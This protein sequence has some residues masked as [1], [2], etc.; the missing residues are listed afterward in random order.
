M[1]SGKSNKK[2]KRGSKTELFVKFES[3]PEKFNQ[4][5]KESDIVDLKA[6]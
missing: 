6:N 1:D 4:W 5:V 2:R 3:W